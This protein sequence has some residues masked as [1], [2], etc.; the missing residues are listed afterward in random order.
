M[1]DNSGK[2]ISEGKIAFDLSKMY[3][4]STFSGRFMCFYNSF[5]PRMFFFS[6]KSILSAQK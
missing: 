4:M 1:K 3:D 6:D 2:D 5:N